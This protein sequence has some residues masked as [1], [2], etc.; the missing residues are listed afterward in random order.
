[1]YAPA[2]AATPITSAQKKCCATF[3]HPVRWTVPVLTFNFR[4]AT[5]RE[6]AESSPREAPKVSGPQTVLLIE[7]DDDTR[8][9]L[10]ELLQ[11]RGYRVV[12]ARNGREG[13]KYLQGN[14]PPGC[15]VL[16]LWMPLMDGWTFV[17]EMKGGRLPD[18]PTMV[19]TAAEAYWGYPV[20]PRYVLRKPLDSGK[21]LGMV[22]SLVAT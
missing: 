3:A 1:L 8:R 6:V 9:E 14:P 17:G 19:I 11:D 20:S 10:A 2:T 5:D 12:T 21:F 4:M 22:D 18:V 13:Q 15:I 16:D 7:D